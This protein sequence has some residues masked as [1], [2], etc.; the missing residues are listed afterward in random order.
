MGW[1]NPKVDWSAGDGIM[2]SDFNRIEGNIRWLLDN[3]HD[4]GGSAQ[5][6]SATAGA[7]YTFAIATIRV[8]GHHSAYC[9][10]GFYSAPVPSYV[11]VFAAD[12]IGPVTG[13]SLFFSGS[14]TGSGIG[15]AHM[16]RNDSDNAVVYR[17]VFRAQPTINI[18]SYNIYYN[19]KITLLDDA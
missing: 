4:L 8:P 15:E 9:S 2:A 7:E 17:F 6:G 5:L 1:I 19:A 16:V 13:G 18:S 3:V 12:D 11:K 14:A 10:L